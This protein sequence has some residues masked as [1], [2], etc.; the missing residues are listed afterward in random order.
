MDAL[1]R[2][3]GSDE[4]LEIGRRLILENRP[5]R[6]RVMAQEVI[7]IVPPRCRPRRRIEPVALNAEVADAIILK[8][9][10][11]QGNEP[12]LRPGEQHNKE[13]EVKA[14]QQMPSLSGPALSK[15][16]LR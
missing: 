2:V 4:P 16:R 9:Q 12:T 7:V 15:Q 13:N 3:V 10:L 8:S 1:C 5:L 11:P 6:A 14:H